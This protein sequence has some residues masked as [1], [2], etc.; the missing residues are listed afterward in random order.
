MVKE[1]QWVIIITI[2]VII[3]GG[4]YYWRQQYRSSSAVELIA[5]DEIDPIITIPMVNA[6]IGDPAPIEDNGVI[7]SS[8][9]NFVEARMKETE[10]TLWKTEVYND[11]EPVVPDTTLEGDVQQNIIRSLRLEG[12]L[13]IVRNSKGQE[14]QI[15]KSTGALNTVISRER[16]IE[17]SRQDMAKDPS[18]A[19]LI[20]RELEAQLFEGK[21]Y[22]TFVPL[23]PQVG[24]GL[25]QYVINAET[26]EVISKLL[27][28]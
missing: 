23:K 25:P 24:G 18:T 16:A 10:M 20:N 2:A 17:I 6:K 7:Y 27:Q 3:C 8:H 9:V 5:I 26:G 15:Q 13:L 4:G 12:D 22:V 14:F 1:I 28:R 11:V 19:T 21:W